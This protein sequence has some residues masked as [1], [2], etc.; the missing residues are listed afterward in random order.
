MKKAGESPWFGV[1]G[2][3]L[4]WIH[5]YVRDVFS[6]KLSQMCQWTVDSYHLRLQSII[7]QEKL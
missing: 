5:A 2:F 3:F 7:K 6:I 4:D 1:C